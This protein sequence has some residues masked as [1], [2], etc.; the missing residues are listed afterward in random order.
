MKNKKI[1]KQTIEK[2]EKL[3]NIKNEN[4]FKNKIPWKKMKK[5]EKK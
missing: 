3:N 2:S 5:L 1:E 4:N